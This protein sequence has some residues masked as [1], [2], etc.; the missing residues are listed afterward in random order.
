MTGQV[1]IGAVSLALGL[2]MYEVLRRTDFFHTTIR[3]DAGRHYNA[4]AGL[5]R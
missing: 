2:T 3:R 1:V 4:L 5:L